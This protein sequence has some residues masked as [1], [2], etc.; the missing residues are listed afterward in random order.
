M[1]EFVQNLALFLTTLLRSH[2][3]AVEAAGPG[4]ARDALLAALGVLV[5]ASYVQDDEVRGFG[6]AGV[7]CGCCTARLRQGQPTA[8]V[9]MPPRP[10]PH[11][12]RPI[13]SQNALFS[14]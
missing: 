12:Q 7:G 11:L 3:G 6:G 9:R 10:T 2:I 8:R 4:P 1:Q 13:T 5:S 14:V